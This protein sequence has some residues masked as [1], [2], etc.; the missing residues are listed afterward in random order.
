MLVVFEGSVY[1]YTQLGLITENGDR[2][3]ILNDL[4]RI[5]LITGVKLQIRVQI[6]FSYV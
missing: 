6:H 3:S 2:G 1:I 5:M 4:H